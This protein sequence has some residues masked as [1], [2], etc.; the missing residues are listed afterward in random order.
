MAG[1]RNLVFINRL[2]WPVVFADYFSRHNKECIANYFNTQ[3]AVLILKTLKKM[4]LIR[5]KKNN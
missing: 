2:D 4:V 5:M 1:G 3:T